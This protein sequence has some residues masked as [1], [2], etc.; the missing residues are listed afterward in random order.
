VPLLWATEQLTDDL[1][2]HQHLAEQRL[3]Q[4]AH[5]GAQG[6][7]QGRQQHA[8][9]DHPGD[10]AHATQHHHRQ[11]GNGL[12]EGE[13]FRRDKPLERREQH[14]AH[15][16]ERR[17]NG[18]RQQLEAHGVD[19]HGLR[20]VFV[21][22]DGHPRTADART[23]QADAGE[24]DQHHQRGEQVVIE[25]NRRQAQAEQVLGAAQVHAEQVHR[26]DLGDAFGAVGDVHRAVEVAQQDAD[27]LAKAQ[28]HDG[29]VVA[30]QAQ[31]RRAE[32]YAAAGRQQGAEWQDQPDR[33]V[34]A[35][36]QQ[37]RQRGELL[38]QM[39]RREQ[40]REISAHR[41]ERDKAHIQQPRIADHDVQAEG[42]HDVQQGKVQGAHPGVATGVADDPRRQH[43]GH[44]EQQQAQARTFVGSQGLD[45]ARVAKR[46]PNNPEGR[47]TSTAINTIKAN[48]S[49]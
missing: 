47:N 28:G 3:L 13:G 26:V 16:A 12:V 8:A 7:G 31:G 19:A 9:Q 14:P 4:R 33:G 25:V 39:R 43:Q 46:S 21:F 38:Q 37:R 45:H 41:I 35:R 20:R 23:L 15:A 5:A 34:Q 18:K 49:W 22:A 44:G 2:V 6:F 48:T 17:A 36:R 40:R 27:D 10:V 24:Q 11:H 32:H 30:A 1:R 29:Q 42:E